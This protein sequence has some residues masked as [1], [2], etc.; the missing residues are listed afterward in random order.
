MNR[1][2]GKKI[3]S[4]ILDSL[5]SRVD[6]FPRKIGLAFLLV[7]DNAASRTYVSMKKK[8]CKRI[9][10]YSVVKEYPSET[11]QETILLEIDR[12]NRDPMIDGILVQLPLPEHLDTLTI[13]RSILPEKDVDGF[14]PINVGKLLLGENDGFFPCTPRG[15]Q[16]LLE[17]T[18]PV[19]GKH[20]VIVGRSNIVGKPLASLL[21]QKRKGANA[22]VTLAHSQSHHLAEITRSADVL[23][24]AIGSPR[25]IRKE[26]VK[27]GSVVIDVGINRVQNEKG[28][29]ILVGDVDY[30]GVAPIASAITPVPGGV[31]PM[32]LA[33][34]M[35]NTLESAE[36][37]K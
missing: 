25:F 33:M 24:A 14:H 32:T 18:L 6:R 11:S 27:Q 16:V 35:Q 8:T 7:G 28:E 23:I 19:E 36:R 30:D 12:F 29:L 4:E 5:A 10:I 1:I 31:G 13:T 26:M 9:G 22:T 34:L 3:A 20:A 15:V 17:R 21:I 2:D 37:R